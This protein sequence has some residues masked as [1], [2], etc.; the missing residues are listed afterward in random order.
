MKNVKIY[1]INTM[2]FALACAVCEIL[3][4]GIFDRDKVGQGHGV[5]LK[6]WRHSMANIKIY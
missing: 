4:F 6:Q 1:K 5:K 2:Q 3:A